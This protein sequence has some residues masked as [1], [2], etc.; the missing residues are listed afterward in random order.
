MQILTSSKHKK[1]TKFKSILGMY[2]KHV[3]GGHEEYLHVLGGPESKTP[4]KYLYLYTNI[5][6]QY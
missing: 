3:L 5:N 4:K 6:L 2:Y 1:K